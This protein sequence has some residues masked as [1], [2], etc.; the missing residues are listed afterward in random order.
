MNCLIA[1]KKGKLSIS[2]TVHQT[3]IIVISCSFATSEI[4]SFISFVICGIIC[5]VC[6][7]YSQA[8]S[9]FITF[10]YTFQ[11]VILLCLLKDFHKNLS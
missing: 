6:H 10:W 4:L 8:L 11:V 5:T 7:R 9:L 1:S 2:H 3:S